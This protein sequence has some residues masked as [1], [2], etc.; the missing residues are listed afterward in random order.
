MEFCLSETGFFVE[1]AYSGS[2]G[3][4][5]FRRHR[6][7][8][9]IA[10]VQLPEMHGFELLKQILALDSQAVLIFITGHSAIPDAV[11]AIKAGAY[12]YLAKPFSNET[13]C[14]TAR[15][16]LEF[17]SLRQTEHKSEKSGVRNKPVQII[18][19][20]QRLQILLR[21]IDKVGYSKA[22]V[23]I[24]GESGTGKEL[25][26]RALHERSVR[27]GQPFVTVNCAAIPADLVESVL[28]G[29]VKGSFTGAM[30]DCRGKFVLAN[31]GT[32]F[33]D[34]IGEL[35]VNLQPKLL[36]ALQEREIEPIGGA[37]EKID[38][39]IIAATNRRIE[40][41][42]DNGSFREDLYYRLAVVHLHVPALRD[43][44]EDI[45]PLIDFFLAKLSKDEDVGFTASALEALQNYPWPGN[46]RELQNTVEQ[47][48]ILRRHNRLDKLDLPQHIAGTGK[49]FSSFFRLPD[50]GYSLAELEKEAICQALVLNN[51]NKSKAAE[52]LKISRHTLNYR[53]AKYNL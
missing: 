6:P 34:E 24:T 10:D 48:L 3:L 17:K 37:P 26:A 38:V 13:L 14:A 29:H 15:K 2:R 11:S 9:V 25:V 31:G 40:E 16:A 39:R 1:V 43:R 12:D 52:F 22:S 18:G 44:H 23:L 36:R 33:L 19:K 21:Q 50:R 32:L 30:T 5:L 49:K 4:Q 45:S 51:G 53:M 8:L 46:I 35:P 42:I 41:S 7:S 47:V 28:F 27:A 20:S